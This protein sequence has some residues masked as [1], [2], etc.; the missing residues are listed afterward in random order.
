MVCVVGCFWNC[1]YC[2]CKS[3]GVC[4]CVGS[5][6]SRKEYKDEISIY[7]CIMWLVRSGCLEICHSNQWSD[8]IDDDEG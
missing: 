6:G 5:F 2:N 3:F 7:V 1:L 4:E 8:R